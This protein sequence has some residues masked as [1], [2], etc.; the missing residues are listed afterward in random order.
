MAW[1]DWLLSG[2]G[3]DQHALRTRGC[4]FEAAS[5]RCLW[6]SFRGRCHAVLSCLTPG[7]SEGPDRGKRTGQ[8]H[9]NWTAYQSNWAKSSYCMAL[10]LL[11]HIA[12]ACNTRAPAFV[13]LTPLHASFTAHKCLRYA[14]PES[15]CTVVCTNGSSVR[16]KQ[17]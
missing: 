8:R 15:P 17:A 1:E 13:G 14:L 7:F 9:S 5:C 4:H 6:R 10:G 2:K 16:E 12:R 3:L 11:Q